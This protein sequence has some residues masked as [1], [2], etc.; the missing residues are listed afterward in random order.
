MAFGIR[1]ATER[2]IPAMLALWKKLQA[3]EAPFGGDYWR[4]TPDAPGSFE[5]F[6]RNEIASPDFVMLVAEDGGHAVGF[7]TGKIQ[8]RPPIFIVQK[9]LHVD[10]L[11]V[12]KVFRGKGLGRRLLASAEAKAKAHGARMLT[13]LVALENRPALSLYRE[14]GLKPFSMKMAKK[15]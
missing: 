15:I 3:F 12:E 2:D 5:R 1:N 4:T 9:E 11:Y 10:N 7:L 13:L 14:F 8:D 6:L